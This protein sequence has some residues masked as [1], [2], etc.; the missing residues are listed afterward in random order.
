MKNKKDDILTIDEAAEL[1]RIPHSSVYKLA[2]EGSCPSQK[3]GRHE[4][5]R[6][7][8]R[9]RLQEH[10]TELTELE[11][12]ELLLTYCLP[13]RDVAALTNALLSRFT[14]LWGVVSAPE[15]E[16]RQVPGIGDSSVIFFCLIKTLFKNNEHGM[17]QNNPTS[18]QL[19]LFEPIPTVIKYTNK[20]VRT[21]KPS[22]RVFAND[23]I[24][25]SLEML[26]KAASFPSLEAY[27]LFLVENL[28]YN[29]SETRI[30]RASYILERFFPQGQLDIPL[31]YYAAHCSSQSDLKPVVFYH[32]LKAEPLLMRIAEDLLWSALP[33]GRVEREQMRAVILAN[34]PQAGLSSQKNMLRSIFNTYH[35]LELGSVKET[36]L[37]FQLQPGTLESF[38]YILVSEFPESGMY[39][40]E[41]IFTGIIHR[42]MLWD[43]EWIRL[44]LYNLQDFGV[45]TKVSEID[46]VHQFS[47]AMQPSAALKHFFEH[48]ARHNLAMR[49]RAENNCENG[50]KGEKS[51]YE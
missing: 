21:Q 47:I 20:K 42:A 10:E 26:P 1:L 16:L 15:S 48:T 3:V 27:K 18:P 32:I 6:A 41:S 35:Y 13:R 49:D 43:K 19:N 37:R 17:G 11:K 44:Q 40:F 29:A 34:L 38:L 46:T 7:R 50:R 2:Q 9:K 22:M 36:T 30:R 24:L 25:N 12:L 14:T 5:H 4:G 39:S 33:I 8:L 28:P 51:S 31:T 23:E 45:L